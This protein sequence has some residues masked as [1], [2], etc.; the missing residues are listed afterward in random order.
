M[1]GGALRP[2]IQDSLGMPMIFAL[3]SA[4]KDHLDNLNAESR[5]QT[6]AGREARRA[7]EERREL[8]R[9]RHSCAPCSCFPGARMH[10]GA[11]THGGTR[12]LQERLTSGTLLTP[13]TFEEW[14]TAF[15]AEMEALKR[16]KA[17]VAAIGK[18]EGSFLTGMCGRRALGSP[19]R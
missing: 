19:D 10:T 13:E 3:H 2:Q 4:I 7:E 5:K 8:V 6:I 9:L 18:E 17:R 1:A 14:N 15:I 12:R 16:E 11:R